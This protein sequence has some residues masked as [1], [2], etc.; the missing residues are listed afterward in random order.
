MDLAIISN[1]GLNSD[2]GEVKVYIQNLVKALQKRSIRLFLL[3]REGKPREIE[4]KLPENN[5]NNIIVDVAAIEK[6]LKQKFKNL[7][8][9]DSCERQRCNYSLQEI[10]LFYPMP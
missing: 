10:Q 4:E 5:I 8:G 7:F 2:G 1:Y 9:V 6:S 3:I